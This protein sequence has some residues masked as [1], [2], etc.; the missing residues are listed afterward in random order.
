MTRINKCHDFAWSRQL[1]AD[2]AAR[3]A[4][5]SAAFLAVNLA[6]GYYFLSYKDGLRGVDC[7]YLLAETLTTVTHGLYRMTI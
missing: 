1:W 3:I 4:M 6:L 7:W 2:A 5:I